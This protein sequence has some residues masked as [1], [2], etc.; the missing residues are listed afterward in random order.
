MG[1][2]NVDEKTIISLV[3]SIDKQLDS[4]KI[5]KPILDTRL[6][7]SL[8]RRKIVDIKTLK[9]MYEE[10][11]GYISNTER[12]RAEPFFTGEL[13]SCFDKCCYMCVLVYNLVELLPSFDFKYKYSLDEML[14]YEINVIEPAEELI[15]TISS[16][17]FEY[18]ELIINNKNAT[19][20]VEIY[21]EL[22]YAKRIYK[23]LY[24]Y[25]N[26]LNDVYFLIQK[27]FQVVP[28]LFA[29]D[30]DEDRYYWWK[31]VNQDFMEDVFWM[32]LEAEQK[33]TL[34]VS[35]DEDERFC[36]IVKKGAWMST[37]DKDIEA[38]KINNLI[39]LSQKI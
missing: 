36:D 28:Y 20:K 35:Y 8:S 5:E 32:L 15:K 29:V 25:Y 4:N 14:S 33:T 3:R 24:D 1:Q 7:R 23:A 31:I 26:Y 22:E 18:Q 21:E 34:E 27:I 19:V 2:N 6:P 9:E 38:L 10:C 39:E 37:L 17:M 11:V 13:Y 30:E 16:K 12:S